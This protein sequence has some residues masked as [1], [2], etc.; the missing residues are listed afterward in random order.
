MDPNLLDTF[1]ESVPF[2]TYIRNYRFIAND[3]L[4]LQNHT[5]GGRRPITQNTIAKIIPITN[6]IQAISIAIPATPVIPN[7]AAIIAITKK[8]IAKF[9]MSFLLD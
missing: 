6:K 5:G 3:T 8:V 2:I 7:R 4:Q 1:A 9:I